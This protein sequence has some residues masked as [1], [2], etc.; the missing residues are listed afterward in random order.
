MTKFIGTSFGNKLVVRLTACIILIIIP[1]VSFG[2]KPV[3]FSGTWVQDTT[4]SNDFLK[5]YSLTLTI[6]QT[7][8]TI[9]I[10]HSYFN[11]K[12]I[13][14]DSMQFTYSLDGKEVVEKKPEWIEKTSLKWSPDKKEIDI[15]NTQT[16]Q[17]QVNES[18][19]VYS[20]SK[21]GT[22][23]T[24]KSF[25]VDVKDNIFIKIFNKKK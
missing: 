9:I 20:L 1:L 4:K 2:Q 14:E 17:D 21:D 5:G 13:E 16:I 22:V 25:N 23:L 24:Q 6:T 19:E 10:K 11:A 3:D 7:D 12:N 8:K 18:H 15:K